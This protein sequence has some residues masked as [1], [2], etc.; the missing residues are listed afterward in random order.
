MKLVWLS[1]F[2]YFK[3]MDFLPLLRTPD[4]S[5]FI[6]YLSLEH[7]QTHIPTQPELPFLNPYLSFQPQLMFQAIH[8]SF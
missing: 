2:L 3:E 4:P 6:P 8:E 1:T 7:T 5:L